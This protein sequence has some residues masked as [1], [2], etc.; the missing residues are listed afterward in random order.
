MAGSTAK[1]AAGHQNQRTAYSYLATPLIGA[2]VRWRGGGLYAGA[3]QA[4][5]PWAREKGR[6]LFAVHCNGR[7]PALKGRH[8]WAPEAAPPRD[9]YRG[10]GRRAVPQQLQSQ[11]QMRPLR[12]LH[13]FFGLDGRR[14]RLP[15][16]PDALRVGRRR[17]ERRGR[18]CAGRV[19]ESRP[20][21]RGDGRVRV[22]RGLHG[23]GVPAPGLRPRM[24]LQGQVRV[25]AELRVVAV[26]RGL[27][28]VRLRDALG[29]GQD[30]RL[31]LRLAL[32]RRVQLRVP[33][34]SFRR[35]PHDAGPE[36]RGPVL[37]VHGDGRDVRSVDGGPRLRR[38]PDGHEG[39]PAQGRAR[40][41]RR[42]HRGRRHLLDR[43]RDGVHHGLGQRRAHRIHAG[44][45]EPASVGAAGRR[46][47]GHDP[48][49]GRRP[50]GVYGQLGR[51]LRLE[52]GHEGGRG[53]LEPGHLQPVRRDVPVPGH[54]RRHVQE[55]GRLRQRGKP[56]RLRL[57]GHGDRR[58]PGDDRVLRGGHL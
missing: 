46:P 6:P 25:D 30:V 23:Q 50:D 20:L 55:L 12:P 33:T 41:V 17:V 39:A 56:R 19:L 45:R 38:H 14:L 35:R 8:A 5:S 40:A 51:R 21:R 10:G 43:Q 58:M 48:G 9:L 34:L 24:R 7:G 31:R 27:A 16:V 54:E 26:Q 37:Q 3:S 57:R 47:R 29:R 28:A 53:V 32:R 13:L 22:R 2:P 1:P 15:E 4:R 52:E 42:D 11:G 18:A 49:L 36:E 44:L